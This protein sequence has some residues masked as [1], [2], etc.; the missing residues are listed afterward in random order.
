[1]AESMAR[2]VDREMTYRTG[3][4]IFH[5]L[6]V[7]SILASLAWLSFLLFQ[8]FPVCCRVAR[9]VFS[10]GGRAHGSA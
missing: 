6:T 8:F 3:I 1:M 5:V 4:S 10:R 7:V 9:I 2:D